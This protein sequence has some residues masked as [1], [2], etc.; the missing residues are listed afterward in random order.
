MSLLCKVKSP[1]Y[2]VGFLAV[3]RGE[4]SVEQSSES[5]I[6]EL[7]FIVGGGV[8]VVG[9]DIDGEKGCVKTVILL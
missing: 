4:I 5:V 6:D 2:K 1:C 8:G 7:I 9:H 3:V